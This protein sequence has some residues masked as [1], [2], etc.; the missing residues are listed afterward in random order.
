MKTKALLVSFMALV[1]VFLVSIVSAAPLATDVNV[2]FNGISIEPTATTVNIAGMAGEVIPIEV[3][4]EAGADSSDVR[5]EV[6]IYGG[7]D[8]VSEKTNRISTVEGSIYKKLLNLKL[9]TDLKDVTKDLTLRVNIYDAN[10]SNEDYYETYVVKMQRE[11][12]EFDI[13]SVDNSLVVN[14]DD[15][16]PVSVVVKNTGFERSDDVFVVVSIPKLGIKA[17]GYI[18]DLVANEPVDDEEDSAQKVLYLR[19]PSDAEADVYEMLV[20]VYNSDSKAT[21]TKAIKVVSSNDETSLNEKDA[22]ASEDVST[23]VVVW[24]IVL[25]IV[26]IVLLAILVALLMKKDKPIEEVE[27]SYY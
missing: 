18:G 11:S 9:P 26:F 4:F 21:V 16:V 2:E 10:H 5:I 17:K 8:S 12:Y 22:E 15:I 14:A 6:E 27:T 13:L 23:S 24:T 25:V 3:T 19:I 1:A 20:E 7:R